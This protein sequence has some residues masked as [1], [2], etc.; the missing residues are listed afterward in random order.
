MLEHTQAQPRIFVVGETIPNRQ[1]TFVVCRRAAVMALV[2]SSHQGASC[3]LMWSLCVN[4]NQSRSCHTKRKVLVESTT[5]HC[6]FHPVALPVSP[7][8]LDDGVLSFRFERALKVRVSQRLTSLIP[9]GLCHLVQ[10]DKLTFDIKSH[11][12]LSK[13]W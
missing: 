3:L 13:R 8:T 6:S 7:S 5:P 12:T 10:Q 11:H 9:V 2:M 1:N 4:R